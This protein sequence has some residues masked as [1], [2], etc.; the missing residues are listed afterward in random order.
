MLLSELAGLLL[1]SR[2][3]GED[4]T[5]TGLQT[6]SRKVKPGNLF[7]CLPGHT[8]D[9]HDYAGQA[10]AGGA[11]A[12]VVER[13][14]PLQVPQIIVKSCRLAM[15]AMADR[16]YGHPSREM[17]VIGVTG[18]NGKTTTTY[19][20]ERI[21]QG[22]GR[23]AGVIGTIERRFGGKSYPMSG[24][25]PEA[26]EL[27]EY[28]AEMADEGTEYCAIEVS[29]HALEQGRVKGCRF[30]TAVFTNLTQDHLDYHG[31]MDRYAAAKE[32]LFA[33]LG[34]TFGASPDERVTAV[35]NA[36]DEASAAY[37]RAA[38]VEVI[39][40][41]VDREADVRAVNIRITAQGTSFHVRT[42]KGETDI[43]LQMVGKF[44]VYNALAALAAA[45]AEGISL[46]E[47]KASLEAIPGVPGRVEAVQAGQDFAVI[48]DYAHTPDGLENV[49][50]AV[51]EF[52][53][54]KV[55]CVFGCGGDRDRT[56][57]PIMGKIA[58]DYAD[59]VIVTSDNPRT[60]DPQTILA[61]IEA[62][63]AEKGVSADRYIMEIDRRA[64]IQK[65]VEMASSDDVVLIAGKGHE[66]YQIVGKEVLDFDDRQ[67]AKEAIR[68]LHP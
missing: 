29:S 50:K 7:I 43:T 48:V 2:L 14:L 15:A 51:R 67:E 21:M 57:R 49:L 44:N 59:Y 47:A 8:V 30:K 60:E 18:T 46:E 11:S 63:L 3:E 52:A 62:G 12:L 58:A 37:A 64:A 1:T 54:R 16:Y 45:L 10:V 13:L 23:K 55:I 20:I 26:L 35:L 41:G 19:L 66:T 28:L 53:E 34:N 42:F 9:G 33:R 22:A 38:A 4:I 17:K 31:T 6:D 32:L 25:T 68:R 36:D 61:D 5:V 27:Q 65:A 24:T 39:T 40:Y 56:K